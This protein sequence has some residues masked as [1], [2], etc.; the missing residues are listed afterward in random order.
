IPAS[1]ALIP[2]AVLLLMLF[3]VIRYF[4]SSA[5]EGASQVALLVASAVCV[6]IAMLVYKVRWHVLETSLVEGVRNVSSA[7]VMLLLIGG[8]SGTWMLSGVVPTLIYYGLQIINPKV[9]LLTCC[10]ISAL[11][12]LLVGSSWTTIATI[13]IA[14][15]GIGQSQ[16][17]DPHWIAGAVISGAYFGDKISPLSDTTILA[18]SSAG[19]DL[20]SHIRYMLITTVP[21]FVIS[22]VIFFVAGFT[23]TVSDDA[24][25]ADFLQA[26]QNSFTISPWLLVVPLLTGVLIAFR[27]PALVTLF[28]A[29]VFAVVAMVC[30]QP[31]VMQAVAQ[32]ATL[33]F[34]DGF[35]AVFKAIYGH[36]TLST[37]NDMLDTLVAT[38]GMAGML[39]T[40]WLIIC[41][42]CFGGVML[43]SGMIHSITRMIIRH[44]R[45][46][47]TMVSST[48]F[49]GLFC[50]VCLADQ[51]LSIIL[52][53][54]LFKDFY[55]KKG[56]EPRLLSRSTEDSAT[57]TG[58]LIP[59]NSCG[60]TQATVLNVATLSYLP[61]CFF[62]IISP[63]MSIIMAI[64]GYRIT[65][66]T[67]EQDSK[68]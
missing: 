52:T 32:N 1:A 65:P 15:V 49:T 43:G 51:Y 54:S 18:S 2:F 33:S 55:D 48:V 16:G 23:T 9:F 29:M 45:R 35:V 20:F 28:L 14:L 25:I 6:A 26:L 39:N 44:I 62:N 3:F 7:I 17:F 24:M 12:S 5:L 8:I 38:R 57:V 4:G 40:I 59:W 21:A 27:L 56:Y 42:V 58:V 50:N 64:I 31:Q 63:I 68:Q 46:R 22:I 36:I 61:Y 13:G 19:A 53:N 66:P 60:M 67:P 37:G 10:V 34:A 41:A 30:L 47:A 11:V